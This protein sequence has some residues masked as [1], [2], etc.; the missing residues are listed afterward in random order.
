AALLRAQESYSFCKAHALSIS[1]VAWRQCQLRVR[2]PAAFWLSV[3]NHHE[4]RFLTWVLVEGAK[5]DGALI[6]PPCANRS[7]CSWA[8]EVAALRAGLSCVRGLGEGAEVQLLEERE[9]SGPFADFADAKRRLGI[10]PEDLGALSS[11]GAFDFA[12]KARQP[13]VGPWPVAGAV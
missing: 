6:L 9:R 8:Q 12:G 5:R 13:C 3:L 1:A 7:P 10:R 2:C 4:G 11:A